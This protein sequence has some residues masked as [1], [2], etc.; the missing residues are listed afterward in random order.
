M[1]EQLFQET[2][3]NINTVRAMIQTNEKF[4]KIIFTEDAIR[5]KLESNFEFSNLVKVTPNETNWKIYDHCATVTRLYAIYEHFVEDIISDWLSTLP[6][7]VSQYSDLDEKI[8][9]AHREGIGRL[10]LDLKKNRFQHLSAEKVLQGLF[11]GVTNNEKYELLPD[12][13]LIYEQNLRKEQLEKIFNNTG[14]ENTWKW[15]K[16]HR[17]IKYFVEEIAGGQSTAEAELRQLVDYRNEAAHGAVGIDQ[18][19]GTQEL[20]DLTDFVTA[21]C[22]ALV[23]LVNYKIICRKELIDKAKQ[24]GK[25]SRW[26]DQKQVAE[27]KATATDITLSVGESIWL[28]NETSSYCKLATI[29]SIAIPDDL[30]ER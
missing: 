13:F 9:V 29:N 16:N 4:R 2:R 5:E 26:Y 25:I 17:K 23:E 20:L 11:S 24:I 6:E 22:E 27:V 12:A 8:Q 10:L 3:T 18:I 15:I 7:L 1:F 14:I 21:L 28:I 30:R 19:L